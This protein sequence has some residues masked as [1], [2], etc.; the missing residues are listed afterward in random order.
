MDNTSSDQSRSVVQGDQIGR[1]K[2]DQSD[3]RTIRLG[4]V[5]S[6]VPRL[7]RRLEQQ[8][9]SK[10]TTSQFIESLRF[11]VDIRDDSDVVGLEEKLKIA[12]R[13]HKYSAASRM[14][15]QF[16]RLLTQYELFE[17]A[18]ELFAYFLALIHDVF[19]RHI[20]PKCHS[21]TEAELEAIVD[22][23]IIS[24][25]FEEIG[26]GTDGITINRN[27]IKGMIYWLA[28]KCYVRWHP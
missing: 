1:D 24:P 16:A 7:L 12:G 21:L 19:E 25:I 27:H 2:I 10:S 13:S 17:S 23:K 4:P 18:Q 9:Q 20:I 26:K 5:A 11:Y 3:R 28:D 22:E 8:L 14:K 6:Q 15:D